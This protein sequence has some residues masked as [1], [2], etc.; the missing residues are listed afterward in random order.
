MK[1]IC[2][3][4]VV[5]HDNTFGHWFGMANPRECDFA[6]LAAIRRLRNRMVDFERLTTFGF[7]ETSVS[8]H[9][10]TVVKKQLGRFHIL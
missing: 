8:I 2:G 9:Y 5:V 1:Q 6:C 3:Q 7:A 4:A 10:S